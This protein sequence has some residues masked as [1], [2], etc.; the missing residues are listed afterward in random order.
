MMIENYQS[1]MLWDLFMQN[2]YVK[3]GIDLLGFTEYDFEAA[4]AE[5]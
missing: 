4:N 1:G 5:D 2:E 3:N